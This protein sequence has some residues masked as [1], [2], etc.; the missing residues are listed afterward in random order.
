[1][2]NEL[3]TQILSAVLAIAV[4]FLT[5]KALSFINSK[6]FLGVAKMTVI[7]IEKVMASSTGEEKRKAAADMLKQRIGGKL[8]TTS[9]I[10]ALIE[11]AVYEVK[12]SVNKALD[13]TPQD[14]PSEPIPVTPVVT[15]PD[16]KQIV[17]LIINAL[18]TYESATG[19]IVSQDVK[20]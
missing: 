7:A 11:T 1:M 10:D 18:Q 4:P 20:V 8:F 16:P 14:V 9:E 19:N 6:K 2:M 12:Y 13:I 5:T 15:Q 3:I 17:D